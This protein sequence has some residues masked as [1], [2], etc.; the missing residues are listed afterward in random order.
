LLAERSAPRYLAR[1]F[2]R[3]RNGPYSIADEEARETAFRSLHLRWFVRLGL[4]RIPDELVTMY[5]D[6]TDRVRHCRVVRALG[7][8]DEGADLVDAL[9]GTGEPGGPLLVV[10]LRASS[11]V[12]PDALRALLHH[13][14]SHVADM[15]D[16]AF[17][18]ERELPPSEHGPSTD[19]VLR[20]RYRVLW[21]L[22][23]DGRLTR[24]GLVDESIRAARWREFA[25]TFP[26]L[27]DACRG[28]FERWFGEPHPTHRQ[29]A[30]FALAPASIA[31]SATP[32]GVEA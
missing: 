11:L 19:N 3:E 28:A 14:L 17:G 27:G 5:A 7:R 6:R 30:A 26:M 1:E 23:I 22:T 12:D 29:L 25:A 32:Q 24:A 16:P 18:Y 21:D 13:E 10:R 2:R 9:T 8:R 20:D 31:E 4:H 15:M